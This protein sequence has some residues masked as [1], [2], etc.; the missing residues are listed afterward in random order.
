MSTQKA[1]VEKITQAFTRLLEA[2]GHAGGAGG[3]G[4]TMLRGALERLTSVVKRASEGEEPSEMAD[5][6]GTITALMA[7][8]GGVAPHGCEFRE[9]D[10]EAFLSY[11]K[12]EIAKALAGDLNAA[13]LDSLRTA[14]EIAKVGFTDDVC[15][16]I[17]FPVA[18]AEGEGDA[19]GG[20]DDAGD[21]D[22]DD[23]AGDGAGDADAG[24][25]DGDAGDAAATGDA[26]AGDGDGGGDAAAGDGD[27]G[28]EGG[29]D[30]SGGDGDGGEVAKEAEWPADMN[31]K[32][33]MA[34]EKIEKADL[35][36]GVDPW[37]KDAGAASD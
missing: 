15:E 21:G 3:P 18:A 2:Q 10:R 13:Q 23:D 9:M 37:H 28:G 14:I 27:G 31:T 12:A 25:G 34:G 4:V 19:D 30:A 7:S 11:A 35:T 16:S 36:F 17:Q 5:Q 33:F 26:D 29:A 24:D 1:T 32:K 22:A 20:G 6:F 8:A